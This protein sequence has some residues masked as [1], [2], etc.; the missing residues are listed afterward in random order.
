MNEKQTKIKTSNKNNDS[1]DVVD[2]SKGRGNSNEDANGAS[3]RK[4]SL[5]SSP[6]KPKVH[7]SKVDSKRNVMKNGTSAKSR[8]EELEE[9]RSSYRSKPRERPPRYS[10]LGSRGHNYPPTG[11]KTEPS[12]PGIKC[13]S[14][15]SVIP[16]MSR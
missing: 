15:E 12:K 6:P 9:Y 4:A 10:H 16:Y 7:D 3:P 2:I 5:D 14:C 13:R 11:F 8:K 1:V